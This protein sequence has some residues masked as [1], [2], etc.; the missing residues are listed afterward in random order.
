MQ[1]VIKLKLYARTYKI[2]IA[3]K[4]DPI[5]QLKVSELCINDLFKEL[6]DEM[7]A[8]KYQITL[9]ILLSKVKSDGDIEY[10]PV[11]FDSTTKT[12]INSDK[13]GL[14]QLFQEILYRIGNWMNEGSGRIIEEIHNQYLNV[15][16]YN[17]IIES[18]YTELPNELKHSRKV[19][20]NIQNDDNK[21]FL[22]FHVRHLNFTDKNPQ[23]ITKKIERFLVSL[24]MIVLI[25]PS[26]K[27]VF[28][29]LKCYTKQV[30]MCFVMIK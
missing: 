5:I 14:D 22:W 1:E 27:K 23:R 26:Q 7:Q 29:E 4:R 16:A 8:F 30:L 12:V 9:S 17:P 19:L 21:L 15:S 20:S 6:L 13:F 3:D 2:E 11:Y 24:I 28:V 25:F 10:S 18:T